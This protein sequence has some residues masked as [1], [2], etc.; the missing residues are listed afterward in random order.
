MPVVSFFFG[1]EVRARPLT[2][3]GT[4]RRHRERGSNRT[5]PRPGF[6][7]YFFAASSRLP[8]TFPLAGGAL[9]AGAPVAGGEGTG[10]DLEQPLPVNSQRPPIT[11]IS[12]IVQRRIGTS[13]LAIGE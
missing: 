4:G 13:S 10:S 9:G 5:A 6:D 8:W 11:A 1:N 2:Q 3:L 7:C 12:G